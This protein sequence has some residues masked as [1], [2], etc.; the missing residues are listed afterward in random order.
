MSRSYNRTHDELRPLTLANGYLTT[1]AGSVVIEMG[2]T[3]VLCAASIEDRVPPFLAET[4]QG[5]LTAEYSML[6]MSTPGR[7]AREAAR[8]KQ[9]GRTLEIQR[10]IG[11]SLRAVTD[12]EA[13]GGRTVYVD[14]DVI[15]ADGGT[16]TASITGGLIAVAELFKSLLREGRIEK[17]PLRDFVAAISVGVVENQILLD[18]DYKE[19][20]QAEVD[21]NFVITGEGKIVEIQGTA[22][23]TPFEREVLD[24]MIDL[25]MQGIEDLIDR[26]R[27]IIGDL[28]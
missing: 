11:R 7:N 14:C 17:N 3:R 26:Q 25:A 20:S 15:Q 4:G 27:E 22:E 16:R 1:T 5:W 23:Q 24:R 9:G 2:N 6:P 19:D 10:L 18:L 21:A 13:L 12:L 28:R 8:G